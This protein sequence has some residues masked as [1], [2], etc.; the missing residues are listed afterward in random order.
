MPMSIVT[1]Q[2]LIHRYHPVINLSFPKSF[3]FFL[4][5]FELWID[6]LALISMQFYKS[7]CSLDDNIKE[8]GKNPKRS[9]FG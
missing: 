1:K 9:F 7:W 3:G 4:I 6:C 8:L 5:R 2:N